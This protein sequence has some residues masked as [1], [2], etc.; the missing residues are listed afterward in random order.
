MKI[1]RKT[2]KEWLWF[3]TNWIGLSLA[4]AT[5]MV[6]VLYACQELSF[7]RFHPKA[8]R[9]YRV[10]TDSN[11]GAVSM[12]PARMAGEWP[13]QLMTD[14]PAIEKLVRLVPFRRAIVKIGDQKFYN[15]RAYSTDS[16][17]FRVFDFKILSGDTN[18]AFSQ[19]VRM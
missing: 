13:K 19:P 5:M 8:D 1:F 12:H 3:M 14:Y 11:N 2:A 10:T 17:F 15:E 4:V 16:S 6:I 7:D 9:I 18:R